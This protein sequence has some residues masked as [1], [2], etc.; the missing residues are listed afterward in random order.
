[1]YITFV[2]PKRRGEIVKIVTL[3]LTAEQKKQLKDLQNNGSGYLRERSLAILHCAEGRKISWI[4]QVLNRRILT[5]RNWIA[6]FRKAGVSGLER[7][8][9]PGRPSV[10]QVEFR[11]K[12]EEYLSASP[13]SYGW[14]E[15]L[16]NM[17]LIKN[18]FK[19]T[20]GRL[21]PPRLWRD[22]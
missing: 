9:S 6:N 18:S 4:S 15:D 16:W 10:R 11:P 1:M 8:Y 19:K 3:E 13:R 12:L 17:A 14:Y 22:C 21:F 20:P 5:I 7:S 2:N